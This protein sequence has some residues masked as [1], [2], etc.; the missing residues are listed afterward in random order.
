MLIA[1][2]DATLRA[3]DLPAARDRLQLAD[4][5]A[6][7]ARQIDDPRAL[8]YALAARCDAIA[9]P[10]HIDERLDAATEIV[11]LAVAAGDRGTELLG[12]RNRFIAL[13]ERGDIADVDTEIDSYDMVAT[14]IGQPLYQW[15]VPLWR[16]MRALMDGRLDESRAYARDAGAIGARAGSHNAALNTEVLEW[17]TLLK[18]G[19]WHEAGDGLAQQLELADGIYRERFW[20]PLVAPRAHPVEARVALDRLS[21]HHFDELPRDAVWLAAMTYSADAC[22]VVSHAAAAEQLY[23]LIQPYGTRF[24]VDAIGAACYGSMSRP[25]GVLARVL[26]RRRAAEDHFDSAIASHRG[27]GALALVAEALHD[28]GVALD[29]FGETSR[30]DRILDEAR[31]LYRSI[32]MD[33]RAEL[34][35]AQSPEAVSASPAA[36][37]VFKREGDYWTLAYQGRTVR[38]PDAKGLRDIA[39]LLARPGR[40]LHVADLI[41]ATDPAPADNDERTRAR[42]LRGGARSEPVLDARARDAYRVR[43]LELRDDLEEA[44]A[45][46]DLGRAETARAEMDAIAG[47]LAAALG[48]GG[49]SR[50][51]SDAGERARKAVTQRVR[52]SLKRLASTHPEL[53]AHLDRSLRTGRFCS[54]SPERETAW[55]L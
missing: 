9:G 52:N 32:G 48:I 44:E 10:E 8:A 14:A 41:A 23:E 49:R 33:H 34:V 21:A 53:A 30:A 55:S 4:A 27:C 37:N 13:L 24:A 36:T 39:T 40:E 28:L 19:H 17:N 7:M 46:A 1:L 3:G 11:R 25:L 22:G 18:E 6:T 31:S 26:G 15:Y 2:G 35:T 5:A 50:T 43:L 54:Y 38:V 51:Q 42:L 45:N 12:R 29:A 47:E 16:G 20:V